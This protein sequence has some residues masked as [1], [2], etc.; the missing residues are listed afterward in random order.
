MLS[1]AC[2]TRNNKKIQ[3]LMKLSRAFMLAK[4]VKVS[5]GTVR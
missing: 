5:S 2:R 3:L 1:C 4:G